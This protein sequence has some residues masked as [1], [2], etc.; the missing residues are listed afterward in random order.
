MTLGI[1]PLWWV[2]LDGTGHGPMVVTV[3]VGM[4]YTKPRPTY[5]LFGS[6]LPLELS[7]VGGGVCIGLHPYPTLLLV[8][9]DEELT[10]TWDRENFKRA[11][12]GFH[13]VCEPL[14]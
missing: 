7:L 14:D 9:G 10:Q 2:W 8:A 1:T 11:V 4:A 12:I 5:V 6:L 13:Q 3:V